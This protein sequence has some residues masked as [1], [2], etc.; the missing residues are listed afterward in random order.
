MDRELV[1]KAFNSFL[2][3]YFNSSKEVYEEINF[4]EIT[5]KQFKY[6][7]LI[8]QHDKATF[9]ELAKLF[10][11]S[12][13]TLTETINK[14]IEAKLV[15]KTRSSEDQRVYYISLTKKGEM[16]AMTNELESRKAV[17]KIFER[18]NEEEVRVLVDLFNK[19]GDDL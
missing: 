10:K 8:R 16:L 14:F 12:K 13:P 6:L 2:R 11:I 9:S 4:K 7:K 5:G 15:E 1:R 17:T 3:M 19:I 18:L